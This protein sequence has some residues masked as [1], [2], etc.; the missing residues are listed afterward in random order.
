MP[1]EVEAASP[2]RAGTRQSRRLA[3]LAE[4]QGSHNTGMG[5]QVAQD[6]H[7]TRHENEVA[8]AAAQH[9]GNAA[10][11]G[12]QQQSAPQLSQA[13]L[14]ASANTLRTLVCTLATLLHQLMA[15]CFP[16]DTHHF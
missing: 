7:G 12:Q 13:V 15:G 11:R 9:K 14:E 16:Q 10:Q 3:A 4:R 8:D 5:A 6:V 2:S 1:A